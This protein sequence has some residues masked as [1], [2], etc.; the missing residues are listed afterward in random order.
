MEHVGLW[1]YLGK[2]RLKHR[3]DLPEED[4]RNRWGNRLEKEYL[5][6]G[7]IAGDI[8]WNRG[9]YLRRLEELLEISPGAG[10]PT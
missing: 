1:A 10:G 7:G 9:T 5:T 2:Y 6:A 4:W 3:G 8:N